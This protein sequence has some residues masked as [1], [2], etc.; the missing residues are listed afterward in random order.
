[1][2]VKCGKTVIIGAGFVGSA[3]L[4]A[5]LRVGTA[6]EIVLI[7]IDR[8]KAL[9]EVIDSS[10]TTA[11][12]GSNNTAIRVGGYSDCADAQ[13]IVMTA[14]QSVKPGAPSGADHRMQLLETNIGVMREVMREISAVTS[15]AIIVVVSNPVDVLVHVAQSE[16]NYPRHRLFGTGTLVDTAR[17]NKI[18]ADICGVDAKDVTGLV[19][20]EHGT[21]AFVE[22]DRVNI[23]GIPF[24]EL[25]KEFEL[26]AP[27]DKKEL[28]AKVKGAGMQIL[29]RKGYTSAGIALSVCRIAS[30]IVHN[31]R[32]ILPVSIELEGEY[33]LDGVA[34]SLPCIISSQGVERVFELDLS[35]ESRQALE[36]CATYLKE[37][38]AKGMGAR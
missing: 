21:H 16:F 22:W 24:H 32:C 2:T 36:G 8:E 9:G 34:L 17:F 3:V 29:A 12:T 14:G 28:M 4:N 13:L 19:L 26:P 5:M 38:T 27:L 11:F 7:D 30:A 15:E 35:Q 20:G 10:H 6:N 23:A 1:M 37:M 33:G 25:E 18:L 31:E